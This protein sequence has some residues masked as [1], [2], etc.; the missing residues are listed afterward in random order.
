MG[1]SKLVGGAWRAGALLAAIGGAMA[2]SGCK[3]EAPTPL[4]QVA[5]PPPPAEETPAPVPEVSLPPHPAHKPATRTLASLPAPAPAPPAA[6]SVGESES[7]S[8]FSRLEGLDQDETLA[9]LGAPQQR[10]E[11]PPAVL[12]RYTS[13]AC[14]LDLYFYLDLESRQMRM[15]HYEL[16]DNDGSDRSG[17]K[18]Y[19]ELV[20]A[21]RTD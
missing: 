3:M 6:P 2:L 12:W 5:V 7:E 8:D 10:A 20:S 16:R 21:H 14:E 17:E 13:T 18:C 11:S 4:P 15:L 19:S 1:R 9:V